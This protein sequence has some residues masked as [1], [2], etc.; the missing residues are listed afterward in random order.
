MQPAAMSKDKGGIKSIMPKQK[1]APNQQKT[2]FISPLPLDECQR[3]LTR[4]PQHHESIQV[5]RLQQTDFDTFRFQLCLFD[6]DDNSKHKRQ[7]VMVRGTLQRWQGTLT[8]VQC[9]IHEDDGVLSWALW[10]LLML[11]ASLIVLPALIMTL[12]GVGIASWP[13]IGG[14]G[15]LSLMGWLYV[16]QRV[17]PHDDVPPD[18]LRLLED[19]LCKSR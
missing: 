10:M 19:A 15:V 4:L 16:M 9:H 11:M 2:T 8:R 17:T 18:V 14:M 5:Q 12:M 6:C 7:R 3:R 1:R 13:L